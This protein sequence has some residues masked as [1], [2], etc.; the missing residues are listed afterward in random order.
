MIPLYCSFYTMSVLH[1]HLSFV[2]VFYPTPFAILRLLRIVRSA[3]LSNLSL[4]EDFRLA[5]TG[6]L[7]TLSS[8]STDICFNVA[9]HSKQKQHVS[10]QS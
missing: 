9:K 8:W 2:H 7:C 10:S 4:V 1:F 6:I 5:L 3:L